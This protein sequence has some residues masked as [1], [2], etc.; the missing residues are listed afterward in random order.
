MGLIA[1]WRATRAGFKPRDVEEPIDY[2]WHR[3]LA[4]LL[5]RVLLPL[6]ITP[7]QVTLLSG[8]FSVL[9]GIAIGIAGYA[10]RAWLAVGGTLL[11]VSIVLD[12]ADGQLARLRGISSLVGRALD[13]MMDSVAPLSVLVGM[14]VYLLEVGY[15][16]AWVWPLGWAA[17]LSLIWH[18]NLYDVG[19]N[20]YLHASRPD[21]NLGG[22]TL[23]TSNEILQMSQTSRAEGRRFESLILRIWA[24]WTKAQLK[25][26]APWLRDER[27]PRNE[28]ERELFCSFFRPAMRWLSWIGFGTHLFVLTLAAW[29]AP[30]DDRSIWLAYAILFGPMN[31]IA[32]AVEL[33]RR[34]RE[35][36]YEL[37]LAAMR[38]R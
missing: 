35:H 14:T 11:L 24:G 6:P 26:I 21:F 30:L 32:L 37:A 19:K 9:A 16:H 33:S 18:A 13:G 1:A 8:L 25:V 23:L 20:V 34:R 17:A 3:P 10:S 38:Q 12:C 15:G 2:Y 4:G 36:R 22:S 31:V 27:Q 28:T 5:V 29:L 7:N